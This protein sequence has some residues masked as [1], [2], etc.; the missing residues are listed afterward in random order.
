[1]SIKNT[2]ILARLTWASN[3]FAWGNVHPCMKAKVL[4]LCRRGLMDKLGNELSLSEEGV[5]FLK[6]NGVPLNTSEEAAMGTA[7]ELFPDAKFWV[8]SWG[9]KIPC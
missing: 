5:E 4:G 9:Q 6:Q 1:M 2:Q 3:L 8:D 7:N